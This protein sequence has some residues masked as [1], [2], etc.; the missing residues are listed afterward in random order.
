ME[1]V[2]IFVSTNLNMFQRGKPKLWTK[3]N[4]R[5]IKDRSRNKHK[6]SP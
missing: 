6:K 1:F 5:S 3:K 2:S 4:T